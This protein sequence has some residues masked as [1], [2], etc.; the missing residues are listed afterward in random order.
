MFRLTSS[1]SVS[2]VSSLI[3]RVAIVHPP[4]NCSTL[5]S[6]RLSSAMGP[7]VFDKIAFIGAGVMARA[8][9][10]PLIRKGQPEERVAVYDVSTKAMKTIQKTFPNIQMADSIGDAVTDADMIVVAVKPQ[11]IGKSFWS[12]FPNQ[13]GDTATTTNAQHS[14]RD[15]AKLLSICAGVPL[16]DFM[17]SGVSKIIRSMPNTP[18]TISQGM[19]VWCCTP[20]LTSQE[21]DA[22]SRLLHSFGKAVYVDDEKFVDM[23][24]SISGSGP[25][26]IFMLME[27]MIDAG[28]HMGFRE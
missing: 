10:D 5:L 25:A 27:A 15:D 19:T 1:I 18:S 20:N 24:T 28:V 21:R 6:R 23:S 11:N 17:N 8:M 12:Q 26:Y 2:P 13:Q 9:I 7:A 4:M 22:V 3:R 14:L 16:N